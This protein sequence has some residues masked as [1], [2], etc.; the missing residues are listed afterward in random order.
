MLLKYIFFNEAILPLFFFIQQMFPVK[1]FL[2]YFQRRSVVPFSTFKAT[3][4]LEDRCLL[5]SRNSTFIRN[6]RL[7]QMY[8]K[9]PYRLTYLF[10]K[11]KSPPWFLE[12]TEKVFSEPFLGFWWR[13][14][15][16]FIIHKPNYLYHGPFWIDMR[17][18]P[19]PRHLG[20]GYGGGYNYRKLPSFL[21]AVH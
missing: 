18:D 8:D 11:R 2:P 20:T 5:L 21:S 14:I 13:S 1:I 9:Q 3:L 10:Y 6:M 16:S 12:D 19:L 4:V 15:A 17:G 7:A